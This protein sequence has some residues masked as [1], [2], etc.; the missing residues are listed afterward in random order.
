[1]SAP[2]HSQGILRESLYPRYGDEDSIMYRAQGP[3]GSF[4]DYRAM[5][6]NASLHE[7]LVHRERRYRP[8][9]PPS[10]SYSRSQRDESALYSDATTPRSR[11]SL[12][13]APFEPKR[14][15]GSKSKA[16]DESTQV[17]RSWERPT[18]S[19]SSTLESLGSTKLS[20]SQ[21]RREKIVRFGD[22]VYVEAGSP[23]RL[24]G[25]VGHRRDMPRGELEDYLARGASGNGDMTGE[26]HHCG[27]YNNPLP[28]RLHAGERQWGHLPP[29]PMIPRLP[30]PDFESTSHYELSLGK[31]DFCP[32]C[33]SDDRDEEDDLRWRKGKAKMEKQVDN[34]RAYISRMVIGERLIADA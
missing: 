23:E 21:R 1:M 7:S 34:A 32:C 2:P 10:Y 18:L 20:T 4:S 3:R 30:T 11:S 22:K 13:L 31:Y 5:D 26:L 16:Q 17:Q 33:S 15:R 27:G 19:R 14:Q 28:K 9:H 25:A 12:E 29:A 6:V 24:Q 8:S